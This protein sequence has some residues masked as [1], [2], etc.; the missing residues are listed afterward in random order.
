MNLRG[1]AIITGSSLILWTLLIWVIWTL[2]RM[3]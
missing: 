1:V 2:I 3:I